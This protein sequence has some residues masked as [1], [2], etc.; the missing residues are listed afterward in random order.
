[1][2]AAEKHGPVIALVVAAAEN[3]VIGAEGALPW[4][5][6][7]DLKWFRKATLGKPVIMGRKTFE[8]IGG[9][10]SG[11]DNIVLTRRARLAA[12]GAIVARDLDE[13]L[14]LAAERARAEHGS[15]ICVIGGAEVYA[16]CLARADRIYYTHVR[17]EIAG[18][19]AFPE[20][21]AD[22]WR[23]IKVGEAAA[24]PRNEHACDF[25]VL[26]RRSPGA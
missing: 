1:M 4:R 17:S 20:I 9:A 22:D 18:D 13:A 10:L 8:S 14:Q 12:E 24:G 5:I 7:D 19:A 23:A 15:E 16:Q 2:I 11:R 21:A 25:L 26:D 6:S 3:R